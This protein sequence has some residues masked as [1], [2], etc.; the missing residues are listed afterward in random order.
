M[1]ARKKDDIIHDPQYEINLDLANGVK[2]KIHL[3]NRLEQRWIF[4]YFLVKRQTEERKPLVTNDVRLVID[5]NC[6]VATACSLSMNIIIPK[7]LGRN[8]LYGMDVSPGAKTYLQF[9]YEKIETADPN[10]FQMVTI[11]K[12]ATQKIDLKSLA[13][14]LVR[15][16]QFPFPLLDKIILQGNIFRV[17]FLGH[18]DQDNYFEFPYTIQK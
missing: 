4:S 3:F 12:G 6:G 18:D 7:R 14:A 8:F 2:L 13:P 9:I 10:Y 11:E 1:T 15:P 5:Y 17:P 16:I